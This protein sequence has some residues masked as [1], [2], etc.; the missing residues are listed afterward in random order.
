MVYSNDKPKKKQ[1]EMAELF[2]ESPVQTKEATPPKV[3]EEKKEEVKEEA[4]DELS[5]VLKMLEAGAVSGV[6]EGDI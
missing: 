4:I 2:V 3:E 1:K 6:Q 5:A